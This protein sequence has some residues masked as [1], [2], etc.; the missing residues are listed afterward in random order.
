MLIFPFFFIEIMM[1]ILMM[2][3]L[4]MTLVQVAFY[5]FFQY[6]SFTDLILTI[7]QV[8]KIFF[9]KIV[10]HF[11]YLYFQLFWCYFSRETIVFSRF[12]SVFFLVNRC[13]FTIFFSV[14]NFRNFFL[15][16]VVSRFFSSVLNFR[17]FSQPL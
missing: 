6:Y 17:S 1:M 15:T 12:I 16:V 8:S 14:L 2:M 13:D 10:S 7:V 5:V 4:V 11:S 9:R 3:M